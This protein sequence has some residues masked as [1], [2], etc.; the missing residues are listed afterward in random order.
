MMD[1]QLSIFDYLKEPTDEI[2]NRLNKRLGVHFVKIHDNGYYLLYEYTQ[3]ETRFTIDGSNGGLGLGINGDFRG[4]LDYDDIERRLKDN[5]DMTYD[6]K[7]RL[8][9]A[10]AW[11]DAKRCEKCDYWNLSP[12]QPP[13]GWG[14]KGLCSSH[15]GRGCEVGSTSY[16]M[17][18]KAK[19]VTT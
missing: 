16:C 1:G 11:M 3:G 13:D 19:E 14:V 12:T 6:N 18:F 5:I 9:P 7:G 15:R 4:C 17:D 8:Y 10:P 2:V